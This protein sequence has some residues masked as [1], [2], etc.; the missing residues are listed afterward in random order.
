MRPSDWRQSPEE[1]CLVWTWY[2]P[3]WIWQIRGPVV[4]AVR[5][6]LTVLAWLDGLGLDQSRDD[7]LE[8][9]ELATTINKILKQLQRVSY[10][11][12]WKF[13]LLHIREVSG[14]RARMSTTT[15]HILSRVMQS[16]DSLFLGRTSSQ[17]NSETWGHLVVRFFIYFIYAYLLSY[18]FSTNEAYRPCVY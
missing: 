2:K 15:P 9:L 6:H 7:R 16:H 17:S 4:W 8:A 14:R 1:P 10:I 5:G 13:G 12:V 11:R 18:H 3:I